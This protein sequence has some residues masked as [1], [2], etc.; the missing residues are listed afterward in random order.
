MTGCALYESEAQKVSLIERNIV[1]QF[2][3][4]I[5]LASEVG[6]S[7]NLTSQVVKDLHRL[8]MQ[9]IYSCAGRFRTHSVK[10]KGSSHK[11]PRWDHVEGLVQGMCERANESTDWNPVKTAAFLLWRM[12]WIHPFGGGNGRTSR[13]VTYLALCVRLGFLLPG[14]PTIAE[15]ID[16]NRILYIEALRD[17][18]EAWKKSSIIDVSRMESLLSDMLKRQLASIANPT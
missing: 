9:D 12:N 2:E 1:L 11:P 6:N 18:D 13:A 8:A 3:E 17:A 16:S 5:R 15:H 4:V 10:I 14:E 7:L